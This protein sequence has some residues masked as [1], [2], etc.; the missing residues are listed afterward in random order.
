MWVNESPGSWWWQQTEMSEAVAPDS[1]HQPHSLLRTVLDPNLKPQWA[2]PA[3]R[4]PVFGSLC[5]LC[6]CLEWSLPGRLQ[7][8]TAPE[9][10]L[11]L[12]SPSPAVRLHSSSAIQQEAGHE[13]EREGGERELACVGSLTSPQGTSGAFPPV[14]CYYFLPSPSQHR[15]CNPGERDSER[16]AAG[17]R[18]HSKVK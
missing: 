1:V 13:R 10:P 14:L 3:Q 8:R 15:P 11:P 7:R 17:L 9:L 18:S 16:A 6:L 2:W 5:G 4:E 12:P